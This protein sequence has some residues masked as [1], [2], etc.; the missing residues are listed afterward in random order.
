MKKITVFLLSFLLLLTNFKVVG[1]EASSNFDLSFIDE[2]TEKA[3]EDK[4]FPGATILVKLGDDVLYESSFGHAYLYDMGEKLDNPIKTTNETLYDLASVTK[5]AATTQ[6]I[7]MLYD[8]GKLDL[9][10]P[11]SKYLPGFSVNNKEH[12]TIKDLLTH[13]SGLPQWEPT[14]LYANTREESK[15]YF[16]NLKMS[17]ETGTQMKYSD[18]S[19]I[20]LAFIVEAITEQPIEEYLEIN[21]YSKLNMKDTM[22]VPLKYGVEKNRIAAT[23]WGNPYEIRMSD[24]EN[25]PGYGYDTSEHKE[26]FKNFTGWRNHTLHGHVNDGNA[27][28][29]N[30]GVAGHAGLYSTARDLSKLGDALLNGGNVNGTAIYDQE[31]IDIFTTADE[32][33]FN[34]GLGWQI[35]GA[36]ENKGYVGK[37]ASDNVFSH[38][39]FTGTQ[40]ILDKEYGLQ[41][42]ILTNKQNYGHNNGNYPSPYAYSRS[43]MNNIYE[44]IFEE[45][46]H[47]KDKIKNYQLWFNELD[48]KDYALEDYKKA[49][50]TLNNLLSDI[51]SKKLNELQIIDSEL[52]SLESN[53]LK[54][55]KLDLD[56]LILEF[57]KL[58]HSKYEKESIDKIRKIISEL[59]NQFDTQEQLD[60]LAKI[61]EQQ[62]GNLE[63]SDKEK[64]IPKEE[65]NNDANKE[66]EATKDKSQT[67]VPNQESGTK[68]PQTGVGLPLSVSVGSVTAAIGLILKYVKK[69]D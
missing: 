25:Y 63:P 46:S 52:Q 64:E 26:A 56:M 19:F 11:V 66:T 59:P 54:L 8:Q 34:R 53:L 12:I 61:L 7:M 32:D 28:M 33:R 58:D 10:D 62:I 4:I 67:T 5:V 3:I 6:A 55:Y 69:E 31:T 29:A 68:L 15:E 30:E 42:I 50:T 65:S 37:Y 49:E 14:F 21:L 24:E 20:G 22:Y 57:E 40:F 17:Y 2:L 43:I 18:F 27:G 13:T 39:G 36:N 41:V 35:G 60:E 44:Q 1:A 38:A 23:S 48:A 9:E 16:N 47:L 45:E 51:D